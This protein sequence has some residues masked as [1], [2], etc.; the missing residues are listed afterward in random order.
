[1]SPWISWRERTGL[2]GGLPRGNA[3]L[4]DQLVRSAMSIVRQIAE[5]AGPTSPADRRARFVVARG[6]CGE[7]DA[8]LEIAWR[9][10]IGCRREVERL[11]TLADRVGAMLTGLVRKE[12]ERVQRRE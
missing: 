4:R 9:L 12:T 6:E 10:R 7:L 1:M 11:R 2:P 8:S 5:A 3:V